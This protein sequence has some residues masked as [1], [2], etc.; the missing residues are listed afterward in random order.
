MS[1]VTKGKG[2]GPTDEMARHLRD[3]QLRRIAVRK[4]RSRNIAVA[5]VVMGTM[6]GIYIYTI[7]I[8][9]QERFLDGEFDKR[10]VKG[11]P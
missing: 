10:K 2:R 3:E 6:I 4:Y 1:D 8:T 9:G 7:R 11:D 5:S